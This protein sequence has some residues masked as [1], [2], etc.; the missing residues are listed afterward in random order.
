MLIGSPAAIAVSI[1]SATL[2]VIALV[3]AS[4][5]YLFVALTMP[6]RTLMLLAGALLITTQIVPALLGGLLLLGGAAWLSAGQR[7]LI[8]AAKRF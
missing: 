2:A 3:S 1:V 7:G 5:G 8:G 6:W 4:E